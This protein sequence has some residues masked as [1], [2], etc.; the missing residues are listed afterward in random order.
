MA[1]AFFT[2]PVRSSGEAEAAL[3]GFLGSHRVLAVDRRW[4]D[5]GAD[6]FWA[7]CVD[8]LDGPNV[9]RPARPP[10]A[11]PKTDYKE[12]LTP[13]EFAV[14]VKLRDVRKQLAQSEAVP[15]YTIFTNEQLASMVRAKATMKAALAKIDGVG[16]ARVTKYA[17]R[18]LPVLADAWKPTDEA[19]E[20]PI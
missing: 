20:S 3:N 2:V 9:G 16:E 7:I 18:F 14:F 1:F 8:Y 17:D 4:V 10:G 11:N 5:A 13:D 12:I 19:G 15:V 6:S